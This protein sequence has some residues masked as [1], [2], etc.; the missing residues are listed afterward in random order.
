MGT[1]L[2]VCVLPDILSMTCKYSYCSYSMFC[3]I[4]KLLYGINEY[5]KNGMVER[6]GISRDSEEGV[7]Q[8][9]DKFVE[10]EGHL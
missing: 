9:T 10:K 4:K 6:T 1:F 7:I 3:N 2:C 5:Q 8:W